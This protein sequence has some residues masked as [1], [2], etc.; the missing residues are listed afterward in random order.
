MIIK[1]VNS[2]ESSK[3]ENN[4]VFEFLTNAVIVFLIPS[5]II[6]GV[7]FLFPIPMSFSLSFFEWNGVGQLDFTGFSNWINLFTDAT[8][9]N[10]LLNNVILVV[11]SFAVVPLG[12]GL[13]LMINSNIRGSKIFKLFYFT[14]YMF[15]AVAIGLIWSYILQPQLG[16]INSL[17]KTIGAGQLARPWLAEP[18]LA[19]F[20][21]V[22]IIVWRFVPFY[23]I[24]YLAALKDIPE[25][26]YEAARIDGA[27][28]WQGFRYITLPSLKPTIK[29]TGILIITGSLR[30]FALVW[31]M[32]QGGPHNSTDLMATYMYK[33]TFNS[34]KM[35]YGSTIATAMFVISALSIFAYYYLTMR[36]GRGIF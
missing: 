34:F 29:M 1:K 28:A 14:P 26:L 20:V 8:F 23:M 16:V 5:I 4:W 22:A 10:S 6:Y 17:L 31:V 21:M 36:K 12:I 15:S 11:G 7:F 3:K 33:Q 2:S 32:T 19:I 18:N 13:A 27:N 24:I 25:R 30:Y 9:W 35:G